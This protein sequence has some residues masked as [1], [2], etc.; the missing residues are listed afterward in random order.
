MHL[1]FNLFRKQMDAFKWNLIFCSYFSHSNVD[2]DTNGVLSSILWIDSVGVAG[3]AR[4]IY[5]WIFH[6]IKCLQ[7][8]LVIAAIAVQPFSHEYAS[9]E[10]SFHLQSHHCAKT[11]SFARP[12]APHG[13]IPVTNEWWW[14]KIW[15]EMVS[16]EGEKRAIY[17][18]AWCTNEPP[19]I[20][21]KAPAWRR[22]MI[23]K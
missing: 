4:N 7:C 22:P 21:P 18:R 16:P 5:C 13:A 11:T 6:S 2:D 12:P 1:L 9:N 14:R 15:R 8:V 20:W 17:S 23:P 10:Q 19:T 3:A